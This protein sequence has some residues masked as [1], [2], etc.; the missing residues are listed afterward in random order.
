M[1]ISGF[2]TYLGFCPDPKHF[3]VSCKQTFA[4]YECIGASFVFQSWSLKHTYIFFGPYVQH[5]AHHEC[6]GAFGSDP[7]CPKTLCNLRVTPVTF[8]MKFDF[9]FLKW[10]VETSRGATIRRRSQPLTPKGREKGQKIN[11]CKI[12]KQMHEK[13]ITQLPLPQAR[14]SQC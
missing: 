6:M 7:V 14:W 5:F 11:A 10:F 13:H 8:N 2:P 1:C 9:C 4:H 12:N 3:I